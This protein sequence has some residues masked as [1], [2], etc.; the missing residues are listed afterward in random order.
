MKLLKVKAMVA[1]FA[2]QLTVTQAIGQSGNLD[3]A[4]NGS[5]SGPVSPVQWVNGNAG[6]SNSHYLEGLSIP[7]RCVITGLTPGSH[8]FTIEYDVKQGSIHAIDF[9]THFN[10]LE[11][12]AQ[13]SHSPEMVDPLSGL[14]G[15]NSTP[16]THP[17]PAPP[18][19]KIVA[20]TGQSQP[21]TAFDVLPVAERVMTM[22]NGTAITSITYLNSP[23]LDA[24]GGAQQVRIDFT[25]TNSTVVFAWGGHIASAMDWCPGNSAAN[26]NGSPYHMSLK[27][28]DGSS[29]NQD[30]SLS[31]AAVIPVPPCAISGNDNQCRSTLVTFSVDP[32]IGYTYTWSLLGNTSGATIV[33]AN[34]GTSI[35]VNTGNSNGQFT[36]N[37]LMATS[38]FSTTCTK[39]ISV[40]RPVVS[41][42]VT[43]FYCSSNA[44]SITTNVSGG[45]SPYTYLWN[46]G[47]TNS[48]I[49]NLNSGNYTVT[50]TDNFGCT[51]T[52]TALINNLSNLSASANV[53]NV[54]C[55]GGSSGQIGITVIG[56]TAPF[57]YLWNSGQTTQ[58]IGGLTAGSY[59]VTITDAGG[60]SVQV[61]SNVT[62]PT[63]VLAVNLNASTA[64]NCF[65]GNNGSATVTATGGT[66][67]YTY[68]WNNGSTSVSI[69]SLSAGIYN[70][71]VTDANGCTSVNGDIQIAQ[72]TSSVSGS[73]TVSQQVSCFGGNNGTLTVAGSGGTPAYSYLWNNGSTSS[74]LTG[75][76]SG[77]YTATITDANNCTSIRTAQITQPASAL[78]G[79][80]S[81]I[82]QVSCYGGNNGSV[83]LNVSGGTPGYSFQWSNGSTTQH[84]S[85]LPAGSYSVTITDVNGCTD[86][87]TG[88]LVNQP[89]QSLAAT[90]SSQVNASCF[91]SNNGSLAINPSG[92]T[93]PYSYLWSNG[94][95]TPSISGIAAGNYSVTVT[96]ANGCIFNLNGL[97]VSQPAQPIAGTINIT[98]H[99]SCFNGNDG[100]LSVNV[101]G[102][103]APYFY[104]WSNGQTSQT[105]SGLSNGAYHVTITDANGCIFNSGSVSITQPSQPLQAVAGSVSNVSCFGGSNGSIQLNVN[106]GTAPY[107]Y[108]W[109]NGA[110]TSTLSGLS[111]GSYSVTITDSKGCTF[112]INSIVVGQPAVSVAAS[113][114]N[115]VPVNCYGGNNGSLQVQASGGTNPY[116]YLWNTGSTNSSLGNV[117]AGN[118]SVTVTDANG[119]TFGLA[120]L[121]VSQPASPLSAAMSNSTPAACFGSN[122]GSI[123]IMV[124]GGTAPYS[125]N[126]SNG[127]SGQNLNNI[128]A[129]SYSVTITDM[130]GCTMS[131]A[132]MVVS[133][134][135]APLNASASTTQNVSCNSG[136]N[137]TVQLVVSGGTA[138]Y[139]YLWNNG[140]TTQNISGLFSGT[141]V[142]QI[143]DANG[144][145]FSTSAHVS[146]P[147]GA[148]SSSISVINQVSC[149]GGANGSVQLNVSGGTAPYTYTW[150]NGA[151]TQNIS[152]L[153]AGMYQVT[154]TD[155]NACINIASGFVSQPQDSLQISILSVTNADCYGNSTGQ[156]NIN[157][158][159]GTA[160]YSYLWSNGSLSQ[161]LQNVPA[162]VY[163]VTVTDVN[164][165]VN[166]SSL[167]VGQPV[168]P[169]Q[170]SA[171]SSVNVSCFAGN[172][173]SVTAS[174]SGGTAPYNYLWSN[175]QTTSVINGLSSGSYSVTVTDANGCTQSMNH[176]VS[177]P[178]GALSAALQS[179]QNVSCFGG[180]NGIINVLVTQGTPTYTYLWS[181]GE[182]TQSISNLIAG[183]YTV[184]VT[185]NNGCT[186]TLSHSVGEP[187]G[188]LSI[189]LQ[190]VQNVNC[191]NGNDGAL[192]VNVIQG[193]VP[194]SYLWS[195]GETTQQITGLSNG[196]YTVTVTD[197][198][199]CTEDFSYPINQPSGA[200]AAS[201]QFVQNVNCFGGN[202]GQLSVN[203]TQGTPPY[204]Y[205]WSNGDTLAS[206]TNL[207]AGAYSVLV[208]DANGC[209]TGLSYTITQPSGALTAG[210]QSSQNVNCYGGSD[211]S[212]NL[213][214]SQG[215][216]PYSFLWSN[217][218]TTQNLSGLSAGTFTV[219]VTDANG[220]EQTITHNITEPVG[221]LTASVQSVVDVSCFSGSD[222][223][224]SV[225]VLYGTAPYFYLWSNG[226]TSAQITNLTSGVY[227]V[228]VTDANGCITSLSQVI[229]QPGGAL[230][231]ALQSFQNV[232]CYGGNNGSIT[233]AVNQGTPPYSFNWSN[234]SVS[235]N[236]SNLPY[237]SYTVTVTDANGC[238][239]TMS[240]NIGQPA[241]ALSVTLSSGQNVSCYGGNNGSLNVLV[242]AGTPPYSF[243]W[244]NGST[245][246]QIS[247][248]TAGAYTVTVTDAN[249]CS[250]SFSHTIAQPVA[251]LSVSLQS[252]QNISCH[253]GNDGS[254]I[255]SVNQGTAPYSYLWSNGSTGSQITNLASG[256]YTVTVTDANGCTETLSHQ[257]SQPLQS[258]FS[259]GSTSSANCLAGLGGNVSLSAAGGTLPY[260][261]L[262]S[263][264]SSNQN[265]NNVPSGSYSVTITDANG[266][267]A[268]NSFNVPD[269]S[270][271]NAWADGS[272][273][274]CVGELAYLISDS[275]PGATYQWYL[276]GQV[277]GGAVYPHFV[278][279]AAGTYTVTI[280]HICGTYTSNPIAVTV[281]SFSD[282]TV[283]P[284]VILCAGESVQ[285]Q[286]Y[287]GIN[288]SWSPVTGLDFPNV[289]N[290]VA[291]PLVTT[292]YTVLAQNAEGCRATAQVLVSIHCDTL[293]IP[294]GYSPNTDG[295]NDAFVIVGI[296]KYPENKIWIYN[297][298]GNL[299]YKKHGYNN[300]WDGKPNVSGVLFGDRVP[301]GTYFYV[302]DLGQNK[303]PRQGYI[304]IRY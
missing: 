95:T 117:P 244:S 182:T 233:I 189:F 222:G 130:N 152:N 50:V 264:G 92:G 227:T 216:P 82:S 84:I 55:K 255:I 212:I 56:G 160:P 10:R 141:Y 101:N 246:Q 219:T 206:I 146:Q 170:A 274:L 249:G 105:V 238:T 241:G 24:S 162:G 87:I 116:S 231:A 137:G 254:I 35:S 70:V 142:V 252:V 79:S 221:A 178:A 195:N 23:D 93:A 42:S 49:N 155:H 215:T 13:F 63:A 118:Y 284:N 6:S 66:S 213:S 156:I 40:N 184:T 134:P 14:S 111:S 57:T 294:S 224:L 135:A 39:I 71:T 263:N 214:V 303:K 201:L 154:I 257:L 17:I 150:S 235:Q 300:D 90:L 181:N 237:G 174:A 295:I 288:Y 220:C 148:L 197:A 218:A 36:V 136:A 69:N 81:Q 287:G 243:V 32:F 4:R 165:C 64:V 276:N 207:S 53:Q 3:Q 256:V 104:L 144:C 161:D 48:G 159:G 85:G 209:T 131:M 208:T 183:N 33:G 203:V 196:I 290:P 59:L 140:A 193:T 299:V 5:A 286:A 83:N 98:N 88:I 123:S 143:T 129:G 7:Y 112:G 301:A 204:S 9:I 258:L 164:G 21:S 72:P 261:Y 202:N 151:T 291:T 11:P 230:S 119:C 173:G 78:N 158:F 124:S 15:I 166:S 26:I 12:H 271:F 58:N 226:S 275:I 282:L 228:T 279:P 229:N 61:A 16:V 22:Y 268:N 2:I 253:S 298:W 239:V 304:V 210:I 97:S 115:S 168:T 297:R 232:S 179:S 127:S 121:S 120:G 1:F 242:S 126:W 289:P 191:F 205:S 281:K 188:A 25:T 285:L 8:Y 234:G 277:L 198:Q 76:Q 20:C 283:S 190:S 138:P 46:N 52:S 248:L 27:S 270:S 225:S 34:T 245:T 260:N 192:A 68:L 114:T 199:G 163:T 185:D 169:L 240:H 128:P 147:A 18:T 96:D 109:N 267:T 45:Y 200:L 102:G 122:D 125:F 89:A 29:G 302:L 43:H 247:N 180:S 37:V 60:C 250:Q 77:N 86:I 293:I 272:T 194:Y 99:V 171:V 91:G 139:Q 280:Q 110:T 292:T 259:T 44:G 51:A 175:G 65:G 94:Q 54:L 108:L 157:P 80:V 113:L 211:G 74:T 41:T 132:G 75:L 172:D 30:R 62:E 265:L 107:S 31:A 149:F 153:S 47:S 187:S 273:D 100:A 278:T 133:Q 266:C 167:N 176:M 223:S 296:D 145:T 19:N 38:G 269:N 262:W 186:D 236:I 251:S 106:G 217:G 28:V 177:Q 103:T 73:I 67:P